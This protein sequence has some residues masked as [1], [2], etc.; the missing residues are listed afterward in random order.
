M[1]NSN[2][3]RKPSTSG[4]ESSSTKKARGKAKATGSAA[5]AEDGAG[6]PAPQKGILAS[7]RRRN[8]HG[9]APDDVD[10]AAKPTQVRTQFSRS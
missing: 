10:D 5:D 2:N 4:R 1:A 8:P 6:D 7:G 9:I 3:K